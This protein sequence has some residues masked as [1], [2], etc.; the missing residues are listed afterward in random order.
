VRIALVC[1]WFHPRVG[2]I[3]LHLHD[4]ATRLTTAGHDVVVV[5][6]TAGLSD[7]D[8]VRVHRIRAPR[9]PGFGFLCTRGGIRAVGAA[10]AAEQVDVAHCHVSIISP[11][12]LGGAL[13][14]NSQGVPTVVTFHSVVPRTQRWLGHGM[15]VLLRMPT[16]RARFSAVSQRVVRDV[17]RLARNHPMAILP[18]GI[19]AAFWRGSGVAN[20]AVPDTVRLISVMRLNHKKRPLALVGLMRRVR[21]LLPNGPRVTLRVIGDGP[22]RSLLERAIS[23]YGLGDTIELAGHRSRP[24]IR[25]ALAESD[26]F[27]LPTVRESFGIAALEARCAGL[28][29]VAM[30]TSG[31]AEVIG[32]GREGL[33]ARSDA[34]LARHVVTLARDEALRSAIAA[35]NRTTPPPH[36]WPRVID[37]NLALYQDAIALRRTA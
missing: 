12:A 22:K 8:G 13:H 27:V 15:N 23:F 10:I 36:D 4:L 14:A 19:D 30:A 32:H 21:A 6:P 5:T 9:A 2:G 28:P 35:H 37:A 18:N 7:V 25:D 26:C 20:A 29:V 33:L 31:V 3:E 34:E 17:R 24:D 11:A 16:W 1:D